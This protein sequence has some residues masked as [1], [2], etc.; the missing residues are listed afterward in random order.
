MIDPSTGDRRRVYDLNGGDYQDSYTG[1]LAYDRTRKLLYVVD[2]A[3]FRLVTIDTPGPPRCGLAAAGPAALRHRAFARRQ[4]ALRHQHRN[5]RVPGLPGADPKRARETGL[6]FPAFGFPSPEATRGRAAR[7]CAGR[8]D[9]PGLGD[10][11]VRESNSVAVVDVSNPGCAETGVAFV[12]TGLPFGRA[13]RR[14]AAARPASWRLRTRVFVSNGHNDTITVIDAA[15]TRSPREIPIRIPGLET[16]RGVL[17][18]GMA[19]DAAARVAAGGRGRDQCGGRASTRAGQ[20]IGHLPAGWFPTAWRWTGDTVY[21]TSAKGTGTGPNADRA[22]RHCPRPF[23]RSCGAVRSRSS[24]CRAPRR[25]AGH[26]NPS[27]HGR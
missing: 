27:R 14:R 20:V 21:V 8:R 12:R 26:T 11:N 13:K 7:N 3:N 23:M 16:F 1:D 19:W 5:V 9:R 15:R 2:Q 22:E 25:L 17:P 4:A 24:R 6:P 10:P 18:I